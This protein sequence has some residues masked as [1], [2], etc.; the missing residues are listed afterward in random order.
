MSHVPSAVRERAGWLFVLPA[1]AL[2][3]VFFVLPVLGGA[4]M[5][6]TDFDLYAIGDPS[7]LRFVGLR[8]YA[9]VLADPEFWNALRNT[10]VYEV[11]GCTLSVAL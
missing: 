9:R 5:S 2:I 7:V 11:L 8:N 3:G 1:L 10:L 4:V 6:L